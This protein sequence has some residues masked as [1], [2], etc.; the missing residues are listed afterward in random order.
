M[1]TGENKYKRVFDATSDT[2]NLL[3]LLPRKTYIPVNQSCV[4]Q[5]HQNAG[6]C[7][8]NARNIGKEHFDMLYAFLTN[9][10]CDQASDKLI[11][12]AR[13]YT[14]HRV[15]IWSF[16]LWYSQKS[17]DL[18][19]HRKAARWFH[20]NIKIE[21]LRFRFH[22]HPNKRALSFLTGKAYAYN[23]IP[24]AIL[25]RAINNRSRLRRGRTVR[26]QPSWIN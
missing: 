7:V 9:L 16:N 17:T 10:T 26:G 1:A 14:E 23:R 21:S 13:T 20:K 11:P 6:M 12:E 24:R 8:G 3:F 18:L 22:F 19:R 15:T 2:E 5:R 25:P 4:I